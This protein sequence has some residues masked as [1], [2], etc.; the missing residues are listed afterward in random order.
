MYLGE[1]CHSS[2]RGQF[3]SSLYLV[4]ISGQLLLYVGSLFLNW[5]QMAIA[6]GLVPLLFLPVLIKTPESHVWLVTQGKTEEARCA[7][8]WFYGDRFNIDA[9]YQSVLDHF[10]E[11]KQQGTAWRSLLDLNYMRPVLF[12][13]GFILLRHLTGGTIIQMFMTNIFRLFNVDFLEP[14]YCAIVLTT[15]QVLV[16]AVSGWLMDKIGRRRCI[17]F[18]VVLMGLSEAAIACYLYFNEN[19]IFE[20]I[21]SR[22][23]AGH[24]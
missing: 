3:L 2:H 21:L 12:M 10:E 17:C 14:K 15:V 6:S 16:V 11:T 9:E 19:G 7:L 5:Q 20:D 18:S 24:C 1:V 13:T 22:F 4:I 8:Q 23:I